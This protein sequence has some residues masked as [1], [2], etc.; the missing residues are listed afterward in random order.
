MSDYDWHEIE[1]ALANAEDRGLL[2]ERGRSVRSPEQTTILQ[3]YNDRIV[4]RLAAE[5]RSDLDQIRE[6]YQA[7]G[8]RFNEAEKDRA[9]E[10]SSGRLAMLQ[11]SIAAS[12]EATEGI[13]SRRSQA[14]DSELRLDWITLDVARFFRV[15]AQTVL[16]ERPGREPVLESWDNKAKVESAW[17]SVNHLGY[18]SGGVGF[19]FLWTN[20]NSYS[21]V[22]DVQSWVALNGFCTAGSDSSFFG[23]NFTDLDVTTFLQP[24]LPFWLGLSACSAGADCSC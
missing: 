20:P 11:S 12:R 21:V 24:S 19:V 22:L 8:Q 13:V 5:D 6:E 14:P 2:P 18:E 1:A 16:D 7:E 9:I 3:H 17:Q 4:A 10:R 15:K 23:D